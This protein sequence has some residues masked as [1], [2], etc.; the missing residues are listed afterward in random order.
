MV[1]GSG[2]VARAFASFQEDPGVLV[3]ASGVSNSTT[4]TRA[5]YDRER[6]LLAAHAGAG[7]HLVYFST[8]S[9][10]DPALGASGYIRHKQAM[11]DV[12]RGR[13]P[14]HTIFRLP[15]LIGHT[16]NPHTL[17]N[18]L[19][20]QLLAGAPIRLQTKA[21]RYLMDVD[22]VSM[23]CGH[24]IRQRAFSGQTANICFDP[25]VSL[26]ALL[27]ELE[28]VLGRKGTPL[29]EERGSCYQVDNIPFR[30][31]WT[32]E[33]GRTW[34]DRDHWRHVVAKYYGKQ[35]SGN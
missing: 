28:R 25:P 17:C 21:C 6:E 15:N 31:Y 29:E 13:G 16:P 9:L 23:A 8:C 4:A 7:A 24:M 27:A 12:V 32:G 35:S 18:H 10:F 20:D 22:A 30:Q 5:D 3:F 2:L 11:E 1:I 33:M 34:P 14:A 19:R 26:P